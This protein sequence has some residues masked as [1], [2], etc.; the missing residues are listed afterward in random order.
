MYQ[1][2]VV[3]NKEPGFTSFDVVAVVRKIFGQKAVGHTGTLDPM[4]SGVLPVCLGRATKVSELLL[5][6]EKSYSVEME[7][8]ITTDTDDS[9]GKELDR[10]SEDSLSR[11]SPENVRRV[12]EGFPGNQMQVPPRYAA[13]KM[14]GKKLYE[15]A[16]AGIEVEVPPRPI[17]IYQLEIEEIDLPKIRFFVRCSKGT[18]IRSLCRDAGRILGTGAVMT[19]LRR[20]HASGFSL[21]DSI[22]LDGLRALKEEGRLSDAVL[23]VDLLLKDFPR[24]DLKP[25]KEKILLNGNPLYPDA[26]QTE[27]LEPGKMYRVYLHDQLKALYQFDEDKKLLKNRKML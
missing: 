25:E 19:A 26:V 6:A 15:Y 18:Y 22:T 12:L 21:K 4:A 23:P 2:V 16:R 1:G 11:I 3:I 13:I 7:L 8:G 9:T 17:T 5:S 10:C 27:D 24:L 20:D 14:N